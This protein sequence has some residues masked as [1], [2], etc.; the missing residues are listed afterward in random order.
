MSSFGAIGPF[1]SV[2]GRPEW[3]PL[4]QSPSVGTISPCPHF[5]VAMARGSSF[6]G[7]LLL[8]GR[9]AG[10]SLRRRTTS[11]KKRVSPRST[12][13]SGF[14]VELAAGPPLVERPMLASFDDRG[15]LYVADSAGVNLRGPELSK[16]PPHVI[17]MLEDTDGDGRFDKSTV[18][19]DKLVFP[20]GIVWHDGAVYCSSPPASGGWKI[21]TATAWPTSARSWSPGLPTRAWP[22]TCT[23]AAWAGR[24]AVLVRRALSA[25]DSRRPAAGRFTRARRR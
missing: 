1:R 17:R 11:E 6:A 8:F 10:S 7:F 4:V 14:T 25:R 3:L 19:A 23:A 5:E 18:F 22:T 9:Q 21:P 24:A 13:P 2:H 16:N 15:R 20:Q 12:V